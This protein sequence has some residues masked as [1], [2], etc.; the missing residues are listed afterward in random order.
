[1]KPPIKWR[2]GD[3]G[4]FVHEDKS[5]PRFEVVGGTADRQNIHIWYAGKLEPET[6]PI[7][8]FRKDCVNWWVLHDAV[9]DRPKWLLPGV[10][11]C[12]SNDIENVRVAEIRDPVRASPRRGPNLVVMENLQNEALQIRSIR[13]D[14]T[15]CVRADG[16]LILIPLNFI[17]RHGFQRKTV[18]SRILEEDVFNDPHYTEEDEI[19]DILKEMEP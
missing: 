14:Y 17:I 2:R 18:Y 1:M 13:A 6:L 16:R 12:F 8:T 15:S 5:R 9:L 11:F 4:R 7:E 10:T 3:L 19:R